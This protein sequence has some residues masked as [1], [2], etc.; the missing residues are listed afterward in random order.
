MVDELDNPVNVIDGVHG[1]DTWATRNKWHWKTVGSCAFDDDPPL[2]PDQITYGV[3]F[4]NTN[5][6][7]VHAIDFRDK[8][9]GSSATGVIADAFM[10]PIE[11]EYNNQYFYFTT[12]WPDPGTG[13]W[14]GFPYHMNLEDSIFS[15][16]KH[17]DQVHT[18]NGNVAN[19]SCRT[20]VEIDSFVPD[21]S[22][23]LMKKY[24]NVL[25]DGQVPDSI[26]VSF[27]FD[28][29]AWT[30]YRSLIDYDRSEADDLRYPRPYRV[31]I[32]QRGRAM[33]IRLYKDTSV[34]MNELDSSFML[35]RI[36][37]LWSYTGRA[38]TGREILTP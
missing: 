2:T 10:C 6:G 12:I 34:I 28:D 18:F 19:S 13:T 31:G 1:P 32:N 22:E 27:G 8:Q 35:T 37:T 14:T 21:G 24:R 26:L 4:L 25:I 7:A 38:P 20:F 17:T 15:D 30:G 29:R 23:G 11:T 3:F 33:S 5:N 9:S 36:M 16:T